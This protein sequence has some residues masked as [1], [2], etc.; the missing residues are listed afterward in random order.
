MRRRYI[1]SVLRINKTNKISS[2]IIY[3]IIE[4]AR[5]IFTAGTYEVHFGAKN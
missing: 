1:G 3:N 2:T 4:E 5:E